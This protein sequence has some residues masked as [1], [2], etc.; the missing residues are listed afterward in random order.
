MVVGREEAFRL[1]HVVATQPLHHH[2]T[3]EKMSIFCQLHVIN[4]CPD[5]MLCDIFQTSATVAT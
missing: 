3:E 2:V 4:V 5:Y 1:S